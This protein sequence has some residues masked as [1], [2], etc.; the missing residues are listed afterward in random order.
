MS[1][2]AFKRVQV[3]DDTASKA[4]D[5]RTRHRAL[6]PFDDDSKYAGVMS[7]F[8]EIPESIAHLDCCK[9]RRPCKRKIDL[10]LVYALRSS[11]F[12]TKDNQRR[13]IEDQYDILMLLVAAC[14][15]IG[16]FGDPV[17]C[18]PGDEES[19]ICRTAWLKIFGLTDL[20][21]DLLERRASAYMRYDY[22]QDCII[23]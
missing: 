23:I 5:L 2:V 18:V 8:K 3:I 21:G 7:P 13:E 15:P 14:I 16:C 9:S 12:L 11:V 6:L 4:R 22:Y 1:G 20:D 19:I 10:E 17:Y